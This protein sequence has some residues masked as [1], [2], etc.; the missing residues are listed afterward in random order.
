MAV[1]VVRPDVF[2]KHHIIVEINEFLREP[3]DTVDVGLYGRGAESWKVAA[4]QEDILK[5][6]GKQLQ[7]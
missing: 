2:S 7:S 6:K 4:V 3:W 5:S 1:E